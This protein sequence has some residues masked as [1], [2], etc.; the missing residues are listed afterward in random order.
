MGRNPTLGNPFEG[1]VRREFNA[2]MNYSAKYT[3][4]MLYTD[5]SSSIIHHDAV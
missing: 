5:P 4:I 1:C 2:T 3:D